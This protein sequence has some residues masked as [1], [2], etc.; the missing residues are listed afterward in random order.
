MQPRVSHMADKQVKKVLHMA[1]LRVVRLDG[2]LKKYYTKKI[3]E[4]KN[5]MSAINAVRNKLI[6]RICSVVNNK[7][8]YVPNLLLS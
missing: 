6:A 7:K 4:W 5:K 1:A 3:D 8:I 2:D